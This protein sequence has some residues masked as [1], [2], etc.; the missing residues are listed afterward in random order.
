MALALTV[1]ILLG[2][3]ILLPA[4]GLDTCSWSSGDR[5]A[6]VGRAISLLVEDL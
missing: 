2:G 5:T 6:D 1:A 4:V 3:E